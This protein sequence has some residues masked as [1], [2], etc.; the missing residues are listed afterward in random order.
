AAGYEL[1]PVADSH[2]CCGAAGT[3]ALLQP[4]LARRLR[5][6]KLRA[7]QAGAPAAIASANIGCLLH[8]QA[9]SALPVRHWLEWLDQATA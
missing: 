2:L 7:L 3:Y 4:E 1:T 6:D 8:L 5:D 9:A